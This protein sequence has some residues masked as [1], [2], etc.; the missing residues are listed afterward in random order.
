MVKEDVKEHEKIKKTRIDQKIHNGL[1]T[2]SKQKEKKSNYK[3]QPI[4]ILGPN[5]YFGQEEILNKHKT[6][7]SQAMALTESTVYTIE[8]NVLYF[9]YTT[10]HKYFI[11]LFLETSVNSKILPPTKI[12]RRRHQNPFQLALRKSKKHERGPKNPNSNHYL[13]ISKKIQTPTPPVPNLQLLT[14]LTR[15]IIPPIFLTTITT[16]ITIIKPVWKRTIQLK[17][18]KKTPNQTIHPPKIP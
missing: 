5:S 3:R 6:R 10:I 17:N 16:T 13:P 2:I 4:V 9:L 7:H 15:K 12:L 8:K 14:S 1:N 11:I 18:R